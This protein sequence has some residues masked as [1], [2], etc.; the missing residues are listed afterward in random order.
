MGQYRY[1]VEYDWVN[2]PEGAND[3]IESEDH[4]T[5][6]SA[7]QIFCICWDAHHNAYLVCWRLRK[8]LNGGE[9]A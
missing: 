7:E 3:L 8:W 2:T 4:P 5:L 9:E 1:I 6:T